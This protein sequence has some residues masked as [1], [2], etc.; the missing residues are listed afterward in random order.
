[1]EQILEKDYMQGL[2]GRTLLYGASFYSKKPF[3][4]SREVVC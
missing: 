1:M 3:I 4:I 2:K